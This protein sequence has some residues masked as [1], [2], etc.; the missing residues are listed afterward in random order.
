[1]A[2]RVA[3]VDPLPMFACG[4]AATLG[5]EDRAVETPD[6]VLAW[7]G[8]PQSAVVLLTVLD[9]RDWLTVAEILRVRPDAVVVVVAADAGPGTYIRAVTSGAAGVLP[10]DAP[11]VLVRAVVQAAQDGRA[12]LPVEVLRELV[13]GAGDRRPARPLSDDEV[14][15][16]GQL[17]DGSTV[18]QV[19]NRAGYSERMMFRL[20]GD[21]YARIGTTNRTRAIMRARDEGWI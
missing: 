17:A 13:T 21:L 5:E 10:R 9:D 16:L 15:W 20:L 7:L 8:H 18:A 19:A 11:A 4:L 14:A 2:A 6:D 1:M 12:L 3:V